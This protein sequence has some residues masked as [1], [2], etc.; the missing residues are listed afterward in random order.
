MGETMKLLIGAAALAAAG[1]VSAA[2]AAAENYYAIGVSFEEIGMSHLSD[3]GPPVEI[4]K[5][6]GVPLVTG[7]VGWKSD[8]WYGVEAEASLGVSAGDPITL[9]AA[10]GLRSSFG[11]YGV[12]HYPVSE[13]LS[14][15]ARAGLVHQTSKLS[16]QGIGS[17]Q[18]ET[19]LSYGVGVSYVV[20]TD[21][22]VRFGYTMHDVDFTYDSV[23]DPATVPVET[24]TS[25]G[26]NTIS[27]SV[28]KAF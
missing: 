21:M 1:L 25:D 20:N 9:D 14:L 4:V 19:G 8:Q 28:V 16:Y 11:I 2:P 12:A 13:S 7:L 22:T 5:D 15:Y 10:V 17:V 3:P 27:F 23:D 26:A 18:S 24:V 6:G